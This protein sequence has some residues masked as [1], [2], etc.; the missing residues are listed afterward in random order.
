MV[1]HLVS[2]KPIKKS[3]ASPEDQVTQTH[4]FRG[5]IQIFRIIGLGIV[6]A[7]FSTEPALERARGQWYKRYLA[8]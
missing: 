1:F 7:G 3:S 6:T 4:M 8:H 2:P 5:N